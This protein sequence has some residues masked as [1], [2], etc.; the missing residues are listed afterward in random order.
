LTQAKA[1]MAGTSPP[2]PSGETQARVLIV[3]DE[4]VALKSLRRLLEKEGHRVATYSDPVRALER[5][6]EEPFDVVLSDLR[7]PHL[8]G[9]DFM[10][11][12][13]RLW[14]ELEV[15]LITGYASLPSAVQAVKQGAYHYLAKP[16]DPA[17]VR[18]LVAE[19][20]AGKRLREG[21]QALAEKVPAGGGP[22]LIIGKSPAMLRLEQTIAQVAP[23]DCSV[24]IMGPSVTGKE[25][26]ARALHALSP[27]GQGPSPG[28]FLAFNCASLSEDLVANELFGH[29]KGAYTGAD[30][31]RAGLLEAAHGGTLFLDEIGDMPLGTQVK[32]LRVLQERELIRVGGTK[33]VPLDVRVVA[34]TARDLKQAAAHGA[35]R[36]DLYFRLNVVTLHLPPLAERKSDVPLLAY[37]FLHRISRRTGRPI[38]SLSPEALAMLESYAFPGNVR[39]LENILER[40]VALARDQ[41]IRPS[42]LHADLADLN[43][44][45]YAE[46]ERPLP[47][48]E[49]MEREYVTFV[50]ERCGGSRGKAARLLGIDRAS[51]WRRL[52]KYE[53]A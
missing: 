25:L 26:V 53:L 20:L 11:E 6:R 16:L 14:P 40:A 46:P 52:K 50:L 28:P 39:E 18:R 29:E 24:L 8:D 49:Q 48:L 30:R 7:M 19:A 45:S 37:H 10:A 3:D 9:L 13:K 42:D 1:K 31:A 23:S 44:F 21:A 51:L 15:I 4:E 38:K 47:T 32:L 22:P 2:P 12:A 43:L 36:Q 41:V 5:L 33:A 35:F 17:E 34:A 27:R